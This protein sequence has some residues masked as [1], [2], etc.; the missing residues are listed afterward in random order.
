MVQKDDEKK[1]TDN[2]SEASKRWS[3]DPAV[4]G[5][6]SYTVSVKTDKSKEGK[7]SSATVIDPASDVDD[8][9]KELDR[10]E[11]ID[12][13]ALA[14]KPTSQQ[15]TVSG[16]EAAST[17]EVD[18][19]EM[20]KPLDLNDKTAPV[21][22]KMSGSRA[23]GSLA[24]EPASLSHRSFQKQHQKRRIVQ[25]FLLLFVLLTI[26]ATAA[27]VYFYQQSTQAEDKVVQVEDELA[28]VSAARDALLAQVDGQDSS[29]DATR[30]TL[31]EL[32]VQ[33]A[34]TDASSDV[35]YGYGGTTPDGVTYM[36][37]TS[38]ELA[39][40]QEVVE[41]TQVFP[42]GIGQAAPVTVVRGTEEQLAALDAAGS[43]SEQR[44]IG[45]AFYAMRVPAEPCSDSQVAAIEQAQATIAALYATFEATEAAE[46]STA[47]EAVAPEDN[48][49]EAS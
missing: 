49:P 22:V 29:D 34:A 40:Y 33:Y 31:P 47:P 35:L 8:F 12:T 17:E 16:D 24:A 39:D 41:G 23:T 18:E 13:G 10:V 5:D 38:R 42:C 11:S 46:V 9:S 32:G 3:E 30:V 15:T 6:D 36:H 21:G 43:I 45:A 27:A 48:T 44:Q 7:D 14:S 26:G 20:T 4:S 2:D 28:R 37:F 25:V 1:F 19:V